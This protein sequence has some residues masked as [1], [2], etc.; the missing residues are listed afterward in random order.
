MKPPAFFAD[1]RMITGTIIGIGAASVMLYGVYGHFHTDAEAA[2]HNEKFESYQEQQLKSDKHDRVD[3]VQREID[4]IDFQLLEVNLPQHKRDY[5]THKRKDL[6]DKIAC[7][8]ED[9]C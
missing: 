3:R 6:T 1:I 7:I 8:Q 2:Q 5:L 4:R 9:N